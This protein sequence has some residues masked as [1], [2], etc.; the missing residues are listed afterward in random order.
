MATLGQELREDRERRTVSI[1][2]ISDRTKIG[3]R[4]LIAL[5]NDRWDLMP[6][7][8]FIK[9]VIKA[10]AEAIGADPAVYLEK[11]EK[12]RAAKEEAAERDRAARGWKKTDSRKKITLDSEK[13][14][15]GRGFGKFLLA[16]VILAAVAI[17]VFF[18]VK[19]GKKAETP[20]LASQETA[21]P[22]A[23]VPAAAVKEE[24]QPAETGLRLVFRF[25]ADCWMHVRADGVVV[26]DG[27]KTAGSSAELRAEKE[28]IIQTGNAGGF[29]FTLNGKPGRTL[30]GPGVV[31]TDIRIKPENAAS[32]LR[33]EIPPA[34]PG[35]A[36]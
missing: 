10:Y 9:G 14:S 4:I 15:F 16:I 5:E 31:L 30:G 32:F 26:M 8:F 19:P 20:A 7:K 3:T 25:Q 34:D 23:A 1:K 17:L 11:Y 22:S 12:Q 13:S 21:P 2:D 24:P 29:E 6:E 27:I 33:E 36:R 18:M 28:F 35:A